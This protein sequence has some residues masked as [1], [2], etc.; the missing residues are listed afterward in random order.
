[1]RR[2][3]LAGTASAQLMDGIV[4]LRPEEAMAEAM[5]QSWRA[6]QTARGLR[7]DD[8]RA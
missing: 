7:E 8:R 5:L 2:I 3:G 4:Q 6:Q 1:L